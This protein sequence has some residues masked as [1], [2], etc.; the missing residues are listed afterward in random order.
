MGD[1]GYSVCAGLEADPGDGSQVSAVG[2]GQGFEFYSKK[3]G[4]SLKYGASFGTKS[5][6]RRANIYFSQFWR[7]QT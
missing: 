6:S 3:I 1:V 5:D 7:L 4:M 2:R